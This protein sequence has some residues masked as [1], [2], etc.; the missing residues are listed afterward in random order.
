[1]APAMNIPFLAPTADSSDPEHGYRQMD[2]IDEQINEV[3]DM[4]KSHGEMA[5]TELCYAA[6]EHAADSITH[7]DQKVIAVFETV[8][9]MD[10]QQWSTVLQ[11]SRHVAQE[12]KKWMMANPCKTSLLV[13]GLGGTACK[14][15][16]ISNFMKGA[17]R[18]F[19]EWGNTATIPERFFGFVGLMVIRLGISTLVPP[20]SPGFGIILQAAT[21]EAEKWT[22]MPMFLAASTV[23]GAVPYVMDKTI[24]GLGHGDFAFTR[25]MKRFVD[26]WPLTC[27]TGPAMKKVFETAGGGKMGAS[28]AVIVAHAAPFM[29]AQTTNMQRYFLPHP[30]DTI[31]SQ[32]FGMSEDLLL[33]AFAEGASNPILASVS[34]TVLIVA[35]NLLHTIVFS[36]PRDSKALATSSAPQ[37]F[38][39]WPSLADILATILWLLKTS[40]GAI[41][42]AIIGVFMAYELCIASSSEGSKSSATGRLMLVTLQ[43]LLQL[44]AVPTMLSVAEKCASDAADAKLPTLLGGHQT[45][46]KH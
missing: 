29:G 13:I 17:S 21:P 27:W 5:V 34:L 33:M 36:R 45:A 16:T 10:K 19:I 25:F 7:A 6:L 43:L 24:Q 35:F 11:Q 20:T 3:R 44:F 31:I 30:L 41:L 2:E 23:A 1:M 9:A 8:R 39:R 46:V 37:R 38:T 26:E 12:V 28:V 40:K 32:P 15:T 22:A 14:K 42:N 18:G 4:L